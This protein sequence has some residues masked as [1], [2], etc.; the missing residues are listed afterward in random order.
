MLGGCT[1]TIRVGGS[2]RV[3]GAGEGGAVGVVVS[4]GCA[5]AESGIAPNVLGTSGLWESIVYAGEVSEPRSE[6]ASVVGAV[7][8]AGSGCHDVRERVLNDTAIRLPC[9]EMC[10]ACGDFVVV[11]CGVCV[12]RCG[13][14]RPWVRVGV[15]LGRH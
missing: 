11:W 14:A 10:D 12:G 6:C 2:V 8:C 1:N 13:L 15:L 3:S 5:L 9:P 4:L 7:L